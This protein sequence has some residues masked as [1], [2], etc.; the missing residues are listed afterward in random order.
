M[1]VFVSVRSIKCLLQW[2]LAR[3]VSSLCTA[4]NSAIEQGENRLFSEMN[5]FHT[6]R[7]KNQCKEKSLSNLY[8][9]HHAVFR[10]GFSMIL[11]TSF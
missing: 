10:E 4:Y 9:K 3:D 11:K 7:K 8:I 6:H 1:G 5:V 2:L